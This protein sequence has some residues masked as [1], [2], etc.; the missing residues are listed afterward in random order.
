[1]IV[2]EPFWFAA[3]ATDNDRLVPEVSGKVML[4]FGTSVVFDDVAVTTRLF[5]LLWAS[6]MVKPTD[7]VFPS[8]LMV[9]FEMLL[10]VGAVFGVVLVMVKVWIALW[11]TPP[12]AVPP[13]SWIRTDT[14]DVPV[15]ALGV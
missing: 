5:A 9:R 15:D 1:V 11:F 12:L 8:S 13:L 3:G 2:A 4:A 10:I 7:P 14:V 6:P